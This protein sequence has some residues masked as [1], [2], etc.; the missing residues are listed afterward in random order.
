MWFLQ[1]SYPKCKFQ[2]VF[3]R[4]GERH[5]S[6]FYEYEYLYHHLLRVGDP[7]PN[8]LVSS[9]SPESVVMLKN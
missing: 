7:G 3:L 1:K 4:V 2:E 8:K 6:F 9:Q 5:I